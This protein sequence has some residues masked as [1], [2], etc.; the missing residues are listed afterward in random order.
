MNNIELS[1]LDLL[2]EEYINTV[3]DARVFLTGE[4][5]EDLLSAAGEKVSFYPRE[6]AERADTLLEKIGEVVVP[7]LPVANS[8]APSTSFREAARPG[9][10]PV[11]GLS[12]LRV[13]ENGRL[14]LSSKSEHYHASLGHSFPGFELLENAKKLGIPQMTHNNGR[15]Y[16]TRFLERELVR[17]ANRVSR[18]DDETLE[19][20][21]GSGEPHVLNRV[22]NLQTG[23]L[24][25]EA[26]IKMLLARFYAMEEGRDSPV[27]AGR[28]P[29]L[30]VI[31]DNM[32][33]LQ[34]NYHGTTIFAQM[35]RGLWKDLSEKCERN[36]L[37][38]IRAVRINDIADFKDAVSRYES[39]GC[40]IAGFC[41]ELIL[42][43]YGVIRLEEKYIRS[44]YEICREN[45][46][47]TFADEIQSGIWYPG[48]YLYQQYGVEPDIV[49]IGKGFPGGQY[50]A[51]RVLFSSELDTLGQFSS[52]VTNGQEELSSL[53][54]LITMRF[55]EENGE[56][57]LKAGEHYHSGLKELAHK[58]PKILASAEGQGHLSSLFFH[59]VDQTVVFTEKLNDRGIDISAHTYK[60]NCPPSALTKIPVISSIAMIDYLLQAM[61]EVLKE[62]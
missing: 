48:L 26:A 14:Y 56:F 38:R 33:G 27:Y 37:F 54:Y 23:S 22:L 31:A 46:I 11:G 30:L 25:A 45:D 16:I 51:S 4:S 24:V 15:G 6:T 5:R 42:M 36:E 40:K 18:D 43:N 28:T 21:L 47:P 20:I 62:L 60:A 10:S 29:V 50:P 57:I 1:L 34:A 39:N 53:S 3:I 8:G 12:F 49:A 55:I 9:L 59:S 41:H 35:L 7:P 52:L 44:V 19:G 58:Y 32:G 17:T 61:D 2:G 13:G